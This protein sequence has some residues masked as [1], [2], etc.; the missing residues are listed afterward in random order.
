[1]HVLYSPIEEELTELLLIFFPDILNKDILPEGHGLDSYGKKPFQECVW[2]K[3]IFC[4]YR[5]HQGSMGT[6]LMILNIGRM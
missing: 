3:E 5:G 2:R 1:M 6:T 4:T